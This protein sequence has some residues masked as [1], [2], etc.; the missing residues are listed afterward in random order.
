V[1]DRAKQSNAPLNGAHVVRAMTL[2]K[3][4]VAPR[5]LR[6]VEIHIEALASAAQAENRVAH[7]HVVHPVGDHHQPVAL[8][9]SGD[10]KHTQS[11]DIGRP[12]NF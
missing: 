9:S 4:P 10:Y 8:S 2:S 6:D 7:A 3:L 1:A 11:T 12:S 5:A